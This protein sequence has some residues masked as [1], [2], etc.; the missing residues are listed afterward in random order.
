MFKSLLVG[1][2]LGLSTLASAVPVD[3]FYTST[4]GSDLTVW[5]FSGDCSSGDIYEY[6]TYES[7][8][9]R[10][11]VSSSGT[12]RVRCDGFGGHEVRVTSDSGQVFDG[13]FKSGSETMKWFG[14]HF[15]FFGKH[16]VTW[17]K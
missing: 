14:V 3:G 17:M 13:V 9:H 11:N 15:G 6:F 10:I 8:Y 7:E 12:L 1:L 16:T 5:Y 2:G 4:K